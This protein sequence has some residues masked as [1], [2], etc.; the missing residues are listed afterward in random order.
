MAPGSA[1]APTPHTAKPFP[2][3]SSNLQTPP[4]H[5]YH[6]GLWFNSPKDAEKAGGRPNVVT[7]FNGRAQRRRSSA[8]YEQFPGSPGSTFPRHAHPITSNLDGDL[9]PRALGNS[10]VELKA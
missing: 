7:P 2:D 3:A 9:S 5:T 4:V 10:S 1:P 8:E 6:L